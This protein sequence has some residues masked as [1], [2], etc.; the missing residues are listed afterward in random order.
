[1]WK[2]ETPFECS[3]CTTP[4]VNTG[5]SVYDGKNLWVMDSSGT[6]HVIEF[7]GPYHDLDNGLFVRWKEEE[8][9]KLTFAGVGPKCRVLR[10]VNFGTAGPICYYNNYVY[11]VGSNLIKKCHTAGTVATTF[12]TD[13]SISSNLAFY[14]N[15]AFFV[16]DCPVTQFVLDKQVLYSIDLTTAV[17]TTVGYIPGRKQIETRY[18]VIVNDMLY[19][20][21]MNSMSVH[22][23]NPSSGA[24][25]T[26]ITINRD[27]NRLSREEN[28][29]IV[30]SSDKAKVTIGDIKIPST[31]VSKITSNDTVSNIY[32]IL[33]NGE[34]VAF[35]TS[36]VWFANKL[37]SVQRTSRTTDISLIGPISPLTPD[38][39]P[40]LLDGINSKLGGDY[41]IVD[42]NKVVGI[43]VIKGLTYQHFDGTSFVNVTVPNYLVRIGESNV[44]VNPLPS[45]FRWETSLELNQY[46]AVSSGGLSYK[47]G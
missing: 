1:M 42:G 28:D 47:L 24:F 22:K 43:M 12:A 41:G 16:G 6:A 19:V 7:W 5:E 2:Y 33:Y 26:S 46:T 35:D 44:L 37:S 20:S 18:L 25:I 17:V 23:F 29:V 36:Y 39:N 30:T 27:V 15:K 45:V 3:T 8:V 9:D 38:T 40:V 11:V 34:H 10:T 13:L 32:G 31:M 14:D 4:T 21:S